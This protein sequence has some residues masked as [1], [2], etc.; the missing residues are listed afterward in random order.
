MR[1]IEATAKTPGSR[2]FD[3]GL[4]DAQEA[5]AWDLHRESI[6]IDLLPQHA[7]GDIFAHYPKELQA[8]FDVTI[9]TAGDGFKGFR[10]AEYWP[11]EMSLLGKSDLIFEWFKASGLTCGTYDV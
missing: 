2:N 8:E 7:G 5:R 4:S 11:Y 6:V 10:V 1:N 9:A 3:F